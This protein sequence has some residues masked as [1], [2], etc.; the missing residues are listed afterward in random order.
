MAAQDGAQVEQQRALVLQAQAVGGPVG[1]QQQ[2]TRPPVEGV[3]VGAHGQH[4]QGR[5]QR[6]ELPGRVRHVDRLH[7][8]VLIDLHMA[9]SQR[10]GI[11]YGGMAQRERQVG[12]VVDQLGESLAYF[13]NS[14]GCA[15]A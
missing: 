9:V 13:L 14:V 4:A 3:F 15:T 5:R 7:P 1:T 8:A 6:V 2:A 10:E 11:V 12:V